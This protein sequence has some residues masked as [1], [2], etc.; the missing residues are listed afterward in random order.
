MHR[1][2]N[3]CFDTDSPY[4]PMTRK[5]HIDIVER[6]ICKKDY[7]KKFSQIARIISAIFEKYRTPTLNMSLQGFEKFQITRK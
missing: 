5:S 6:Y 7:T 2:S 4:L 3:S 1:K